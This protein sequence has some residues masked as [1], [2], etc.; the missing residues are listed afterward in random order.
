[1]CFCYNKNLLA[2]TAGSPEND[3]GTQS[4]KIS[5]ARHI[6]RNFPVNG[7]TGKNSDFNRKK[8]ESVTEKPLLNPLGSQNNRQHTPF[9]F[10]CSPKGEK[11]ILFRTL[12]GETSKSQ[13]RDL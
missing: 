12:Q 5:I 6:G 7:M 10:H 1:M 9:G 3:F 2:D 11:S 4:F 8:Q 13:W